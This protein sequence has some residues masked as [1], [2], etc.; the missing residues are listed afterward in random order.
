DTFSTGNTNQ[1][2]V[3][4]GLFVAGGIVRERMTN[5]TMQIEVALTL[6]ST[7]HV[8]FDWYTTDGSAHAGQDYVGKTNSGMIAAGLTNTFV[9]VD[10]LPDS[11]FEA[12]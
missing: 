1:P 10:V 12:P 4:P 6:P 11:V 5:V 3:G 9:T 8:T 7:N 2:P